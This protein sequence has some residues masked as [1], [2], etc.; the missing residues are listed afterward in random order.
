MTSSLIK[1]QLSLIEGAVADF[2][3][4]HDAL[5]RGYGIATEQLERE[6]HDKI[7]AAFRN[8]PDLKAL[9]PELWTAIDAGRD[10]ADD[11]F[12]IRAAVQ[13]ARRILAKDDPAAT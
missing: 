12:E 7:R 11:G 9:L 5:D 1:S 3:S 13:R 10:V 2:G 4:A 6:G 8:A